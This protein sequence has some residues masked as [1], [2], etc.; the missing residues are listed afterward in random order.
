MGSCVIS[1]PAPCL[2]PGVRSVGTISLCNIGFC[3]KFS[4][5]SYLK[6]GVGSIGINT[7]NYGQSEIGTRNK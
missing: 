3:I 6:P 4:P 5:P 1:P 2:E 7:I